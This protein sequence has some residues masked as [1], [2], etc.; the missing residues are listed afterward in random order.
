MHSTNLCTM[1]SIILKI[2]INYTAIINFGTLYPLF[3]LCVCDPF[4]FGLLS[5]T[6]PQHNFTCDLLISVVLSQSFWLGN[7][8]CM[9]VCIQYI[10]T[11]QT[12]T[13]IRF[14]R[15]YSLPPKLMVKSIYISF[16]KISN[17]NFKIFIF[18]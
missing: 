1:W 11:Y 13:I 4:F 3:K 7:Y 15:F 12:K 9:C 16:S 17:K 14:T 18:V 5:A 10:Y 8:I 2:K 6:N